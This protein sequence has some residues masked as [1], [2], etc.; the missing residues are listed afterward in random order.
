MREEDSILPA[1]VLP[2]MPMLW[3]RSYRAD[4]RVLALANRHYNRQN[5]DSKQFVPPGSCLVLASAPSQHEEADAL[6][7]TL[8]PKAEYVQHEWAGAWS[9][10]LFRNESVILS[11]DL[12]RQAVAAT[13]WK[14]GSPPPQGFITFVDRTQTRPKKHPGFCYIMAGWHPCG[15][16]KDRGLYAFRL[17]PGEMPP[18]LEP[19]PPLRPLGELPMFNDYRRPLLTAK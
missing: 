19:L 7:V 16:T 6:W 9:C 10:T 15:R 5:P 17:G 11:S 2:D 3:H 13:V 12:I 4:P 8:A 1:S 18:S 14:Y